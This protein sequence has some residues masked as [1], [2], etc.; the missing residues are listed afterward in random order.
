MRSRHLLGLERHIRAKARR[1]GWTYAEGRDRLL[2][3]IP[4]GG[5]I[6]FHLGAFRHAFATATPSWTI[7][8]KAVWAP[9]YNNS[10]RRAQLLINRALEALSRFKE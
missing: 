4:G 1:L 3:A 7:G 10:R 9:P 6:N 5:F 8:T 2:F